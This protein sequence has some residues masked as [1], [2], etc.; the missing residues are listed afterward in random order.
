MINVLLQK[1]RNE[2]T[3][4]PVS[5]HTSSKAKEDVVLLV[6]FLSLNYVLKWYRK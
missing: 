1:S 2:I 5:A 4:T 3:I 6:R